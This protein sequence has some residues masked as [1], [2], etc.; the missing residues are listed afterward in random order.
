MARRKV[1]LHGCIVLDV[2][3]GEGAYTAW[4]RLEAALDGINDEG[5]D[6]GGD[7]RVTDY[8]ATRMLDPNGTSTN[9]DQITS[10][11]PKWITKVSK[12]KDTS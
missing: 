9:K 6:L 3:D 1:E 11:Y 7:V 4:Q 2:P 5:L 8:Y 12:G 10:H